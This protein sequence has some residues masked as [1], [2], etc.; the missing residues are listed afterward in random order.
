MSLGGARL[1]QGAV[2]G[3]PWQPGLG[4]PLSPGALWV[5][6]GRGRCP[7]VIRLDMQAL[8]MFIREEMVIEDNAVQVVEV[9]WQ[10]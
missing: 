3:L 7:C 8:P 6:S 5:S 4:R 2:S 9:V 10:V 1:H